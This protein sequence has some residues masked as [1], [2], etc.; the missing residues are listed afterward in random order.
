MGGKWRNAL[1][2]TYSQDKAVF[3]NV[4][5]AVKHVLAALH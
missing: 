2:V 3:A 5:I 1:P 4:C